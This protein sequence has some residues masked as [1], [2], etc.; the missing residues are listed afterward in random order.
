MNR[1]PVSPRMNKVQNDDPSCIEPID[2]N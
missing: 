1:H 2:L